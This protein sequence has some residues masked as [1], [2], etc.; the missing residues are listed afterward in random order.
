LPDSFATEAKANDSKKDDV[1]KKIDDD[2]HKR[3]RGAKTAL[4][5]EIAPGFFYVWARPSALNS[6]KRGC[7]NRCQLSD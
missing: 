1:D 2:I 3:S 7:Q 6:G 4:E 5:R